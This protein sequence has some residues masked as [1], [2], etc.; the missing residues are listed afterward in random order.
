MAKPQPSLEALELALREVQVQHA[1]YKAVLRATAEGDFSLSASA[2]HAWLDADASQFDTPLRT[3]L[4]LMTFATYLKAIASKPFPSL[5]SID[6]D[7]FLQ[8]GIIT[9]TTMHPARYS[10]NELMGVLSRLCD[11]WGDAYCVRGVNALMAAMIHRLA[12]C[13]TTLLEPDV[14][15]DS[16]FCVELPGIAGRIAAEDK[17]IEFNAV[18]KKMS[19]CSPEEIA[20]ADAADAKMLA[21]RT[22]RHVRPNI[23]MLTFPEPI[24]RDMAMQLRMLDKKRLITATRNGA[25]LYD[26]AVVTLQKCYTRHVMDDRM[27]FEFRR[28][29][30]PGDEERYM[31]QCPLLAVKPKAVLLMYRPMRV[32]VPDSKLM[33]LLKDPTDT[34]SALTVT[35]RL[36]GEDVIRITPSRVPWDAHD[37]VSLRFIAHQLACVTPDTTFIAAPE[38]SPYAVIA[39]YLCLRGVAIASTSTR[40]GT[41]E[42]EAHAADISGMSLAT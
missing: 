15:D 41:T 5:A 20:A 23:G 8:I 31:R 18:R 13:A 34:A 35:K 39:R 27:E 40:T 2:G 24:F 36:Y 10:V 25:L 26:N 28:L 22:Q 7:A 17:A 16:R 4:T 38:V 14:G 1:N 12:E 32:V 9:A 19:V 42:E 21:W 33:E 30:A 6:G 11:G 29:L 3:S 37:H